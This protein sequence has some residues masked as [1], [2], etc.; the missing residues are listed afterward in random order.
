MLFKMVIL[1][2]LSML[3]NPPILKTLARYPKHVYR[4]S[5]ALYGLK[6][7]PRAWYERL[8]DFLIE[9]GFKIGKVDTTL[10][11]KKM[12]GETFI[13]QVYVDDIIFGSTNE[14][15]CKEFGDLMSKEFEMSMIG[16][17][18]FFLGF[19]VK[20]MK[21]GVFIS[22][23]KYTHDLLKRFEIMECKPIKTLMASNGHLDL[24]E[25][26]SPIDKTLYRSMI[27]SLLYLTASR[28]DII[29]SVCMCARY[30][31]MPME[32]RFSQVGHSI[33]F[34]AS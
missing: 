16:E 12:N 7:A 21:E 1:M 22:Q 3:S 29:F 17:L 8:R 5:K 10:F 34:G 13:C 24:D 15:F 23:E 20:Q 9:K 31:A 11:T 19:Q 2:T 25:G 27:G 30:Q 4:L 18:S 26:G 28:P 14:D 32:S 33:S 6:H